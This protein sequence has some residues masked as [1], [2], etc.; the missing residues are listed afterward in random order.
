MTSVSGRSAPEFSVDRDGTWRHRGEPVRRESLL[1]LFAS[2]LV[3]EPGG[4][5]LLV[6]PGQRVAVDVADAPLLI[7]DA[8]QESD[9]HPTRLIL[10]TS[11]GQETPVD[12]SRPLRLRGDRVLGEVRLYQ[13]LDGGVE[14]LVH[15]N[16]FYRL[17]EMAEPHE[18]DGRLGIRSDGEFFALE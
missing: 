4:R 2:M 13:E 7:T 3:R 10:V 15:R 9:R 11:M 1:R 12:R 18:V 5:Y 14:A 16:V 8:R 17:A 6:G